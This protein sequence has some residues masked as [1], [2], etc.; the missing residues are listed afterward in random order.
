M[1]Q[2]QATVSIGVSTAPVAVSART[3]DLS[4]IR[5]EVVGSLLTSLCARDRLTAEHSWRVARY[6]LLSTGDQF[7]FVDRLH[8]GVAGLLHDIGKIGIPDW[9]LK[10][11]GA[12]NGYESTVMRMHDAIGVET[13]RAALMNESV[14]DI[15]REHCT[16]L[17]SDLDFESHSDSSRI[18]RIVDA[19]DAMVTDDVYRLGMSVPDA[20]Q[21]VH[22][23]AGSQFDPLWLHRLHG[24]LERLDRQIEK[25]H[26]ASRLHATRVLQYLPLLSVA[27]DNEDEKT[28]LS[29]AEKVGE[30]TDNR[31]LFAQAR[32]IS[33]AG[34]IS[35][36]PLAEFWQTLWNEQ[37]AYLI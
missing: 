20:L 30:T 5:F 24:T 17:G 27:L 7:G 9:V 13:L 28:I 1:V 29:V 22:R 32:D 3:R 4:P 36:K 26:H 16:S 33:S 34:E 21:E 10:K 19:F 12:L 8:L 25:P 6:C 15:I 18:L 2:T 14:I 11:P 23:C 37:L 35:R 31:A